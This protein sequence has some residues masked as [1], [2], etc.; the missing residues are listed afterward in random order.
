MVDPQPTLV[1]FLVRYVLLPRELLPQIEINSN[2]PDKP[3]GTAVSSPTELPMPLVGL[4]TDVNC[5]QGRWC[6][7]IAAPQL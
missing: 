1:E 3:P 2:L 7:P 6:K 4:V 5:D